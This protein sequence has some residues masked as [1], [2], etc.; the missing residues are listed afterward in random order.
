[1][2]VFMNSR[3]SRRG[4]SVSAFVTCAPVTCRRCLYQPMTT[5]A[6]R[7]RAPVAANIHMGRLAQA[8]K[9]VAAAVAAVAISLAGVGGFPGSAMAASKKAS[10]S[11]TTATKQLRYDGRQELGH[12]E[13]AFSLALTGG[14]FAALAVMAYRKNRKE[15]ELETVRIK[16]EV[17]RLEKL[18]AE[19]EN[20]EE[21]DDAL[22]DDEFMAELNKRIAQDAATEGRDD[23]E[24]DDDSQEKD[25][26]A[27]STDPKAP[28]T[29]TLDRPTSDGE[30]SGNKPSK[31]SDDIDKLRRMWAADSPDNEDQRNKK[32]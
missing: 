22:D 9:R 5:S 31:A 27:D 12:G 30:Q 16:E 29:A 2:K 4:S 6:R 28:G 17:E 7:S 19:F 11:S 14:A 13:K 24:N 3:I 1:M 18:K 25:S 20:V 26:T 10:E 21:D 15:D 8:A 23:H 32:Q